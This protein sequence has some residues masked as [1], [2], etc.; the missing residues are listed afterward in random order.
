MMK[1]VEYSVEPMKSIWGVTI[2]IHD[3]EAM[4]ATL[5]NKLTGFTLDEAIA[6]A[7]KRLNPVGF[8][9]EKE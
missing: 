6:S 2:R 3:E 5:M 4:S 8:V 9:V 1:R 7:N